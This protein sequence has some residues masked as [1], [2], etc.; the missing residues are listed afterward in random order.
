MPNRHWMHLEVLV[1]GILFGTEFVPLF[2][3][4]RMVPEA[5]I[6]YNTGKIELAPNM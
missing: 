3:R 2:E 5:P 6:P 4:A 1:I